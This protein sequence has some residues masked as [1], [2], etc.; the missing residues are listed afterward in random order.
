MN[1]KVSI[2]IAVYN[3]EK[4][5]RECLDSLINQS[6]R[7]LQIICID[8]A[9]TDNSLNILHEYAKRDSRILVLHNETNCGQSKT[10]NHGLQYADGKYCGML[11]SDDWFAPDTI[12]KVVNTFNNYPQCDTVLLDLI[13]VY[14]DGTNKQYESNTFKRTFSGHE[15]MKLSLNWNIHGLY[16]TRTEIHKKHPYDE[17]TRYTADDITTKLHFF[18]S[19]EVRMSDAKYFYRQHDESISKAITIRQFDMVIADFSLKK[20]LEKITT[21]IDT[22]VTHEQLRWYHL[23]NYW[24][25]YFVNKSQFTIDEQAQIKATLTQ[26]SRTIDNS[27][28]PFKLKLRTLYIPFMGV[29]GMKLWAKVWCGLRR[30]TPNFLLKKRLDL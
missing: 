15:A 4:Y 12:E 11:D 27:L 13:L 29:W 26:Y 23:I 10:R 1:D 17:S 3:T 14:P 2:L 20:H 16:F 19:R 28:I 25:Y 7:N 8:D 24:D 9:S 6:H 21:D 30:A 18:E 5:L 22:F